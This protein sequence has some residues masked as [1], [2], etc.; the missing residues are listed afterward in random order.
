MNLTHTVGD[1]R[2]FINAARPA[3]RPYTIGTTFPT[4]V[5]D[6]AG[7]ACTVKEAGPRGVGVVQSW[8]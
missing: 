3:G 7:D 1:L 6:P 4:R 5:L 8:V 2:G